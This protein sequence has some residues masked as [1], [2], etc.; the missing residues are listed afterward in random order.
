MLLATKSSNNN[1]KKTSDKRSQTL[2]TLQNVTNLIFIELDNNIMSELFTK[3]TAL[4]YSI[5]GIE[6]SNTAFP[7]E[8]KL[9]FFNI[10][11]A[12]KIKDKNMKYLTG[13]YTYIPLITPISLSKEVLN[14]LTFLEE[15]D[16][17]RSKISLISLIKSIT[18]PN[19]SKLFGVNYI[20]SNIFKISISSKY[21]PE[22]NRN[23]NLL[24]FIKFINI[25]HN[26]N[27]D[28][29]NIH[30]K[31]LTT[32]KLVL[33]PLVYKDY[34]RRYLYL[35][36]KLYLEDTTFQELFLSN[37]LV[38]R[39]RILEEIYDLDIFRESVTSF[40]KKWITRS[41]ICK[42]DISF[43]EMLNNDTSNNSNGDLL[44]PEDIIIN[45]E[46]PRKETL[47]SIRNIYN[48][49]YNLTRVVNNTS[50]KT[51]SLNLNIL[52]ENI[53]MLAQEY[54]DL[55]PIEINK[56]TFSTG[57]L[58]SSI[59]NVNIPTNINYK[60][61]I[62]PTRNFDLSGFTDSE[63]LEILFQIDTIITSEN[64]HVFKDLREAIGDK[65]GKI[66]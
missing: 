3:I 26:L 20:L 43:L 6:V 17:K 55:P 48:E 59:N 19:I 46:E 64:Q 31:R 24:D 9:M 50:H 12:Q 13:K 32:S 47:N 53:N 4:K 45:T 61:N 21:F 41:K 18:I 65:L 63:L 36:S 37:Y 34:L 58:F 30:E 27:L 28:I 1:E 54:L 62:I 40:F 52:T 44:L 5:I 15:V 51:P 23:N 33:N 29:D 39:R 14:K 10:F 16:F 2:Q 38:N 35:L 11:D 49:I 66:N 8:S 7:N 56:D 60:H 25:S 42:D 57:I 22:T